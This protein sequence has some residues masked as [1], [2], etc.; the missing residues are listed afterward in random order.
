M[1]HHER[2]SN[3]EVGLLLLKDTKLLLKLKQNLNSLYSIAF[4]KYI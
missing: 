4:K 3:C 2:V 1:L